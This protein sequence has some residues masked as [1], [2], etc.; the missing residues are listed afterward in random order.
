MAKQ[1]G[2]VQEFY[3]DVGIE[4]VRWQSPRRMTGWLRHDRADVKC[5]SGE[6]RRGGVYEGACLIIAMKSP[7]SLLLR[8]DT[9]Q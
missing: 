5:T 6:R 7:S 8:S 3:L 2:S 9:T 1:Q 4:N